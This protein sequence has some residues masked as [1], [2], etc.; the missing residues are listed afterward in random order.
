MA[1]IASRLSDDETYRCLLTV[2]GV[3]PRTATAL[4]TMVDVSL[5]DGDDRLASYCGLALADRRS[6]TS[7][8]STSAA[9]SGKRQLKNLLI[10][11]C[12]SLVGSKGR[13]GRYYDE[14]RARGMGHRRAL[15]G[16]ARKRLGVIYAIMID[17]VPYV[18]PPAGPD[19]EN[20]APCLPPTTPSRART[21]GSGP[22]SGS[23]GD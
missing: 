9:R 12:N 21:P 23:T 19:V 16:V 3:G 6:G 13:F 7:V 8:D 22:C 2:P 18:E 15:K 4:V 11:S 14:C 5:F 17:R 10:F 1:D 20:S